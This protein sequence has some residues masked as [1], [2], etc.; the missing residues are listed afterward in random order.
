DTG[1]IITT[2]AGGGIGGDGGPA[3]S[4]ALD[5]PQ[6]VAVDAA[7]NLFIAEFD[8]P[9]VRKVDTAGII[10]TVAGNG[11][12]GFFGDGGPATSALL[13]EPAGVAVDA[14]GNLFIADSG[15][16]RIRKVTGGATAG[17]TVAINQAAGQA[18]PTG[19]EPINFTVVFNEP[20]TGFGE[21]TLGGTA[22]DGATTA[23]IT[24][25]VPG[26]LYNVE[27]INIS[28]PGTV[29]ASIPAGVATG[30]LSGLPNAVSVSIDNEVTFNPLLA[31]LTITKTDSPD[32]VTSNGTLTYTITVENIG[33]GDAADVTV[34][35]TLPT[36]VTFVSCVPSVG[37]C[38]ELA[39]IVTASLGTVGVEIIRTVTITV[40]APTVTTEP[41]FLTNTASVATT[42]P[43]TNPDNNQIS[44][45]TTVNPTGPAPQ[46]GVPNGGFIPWMAVD[47]QSPDTVYAG[48]NA[49]GIYKS[50]NRGFS[51]T[52]INNGLE[53][54]PH[55]H[56]IAID[57][58]TPSTV[59]VG[60]ATGGVLKSLDGGLSWSDSN[61]QTTLITD[62]NVENIAIDPVTPTTL[63]AAT[64]ASGVYKSTD[65]G[66]NWDPLTGFTSTNAFRIAIDPSDP[67][68]L[69]VGTL[70]D[71]VFKSTDGGANWSNVGTVSSGLTNLVV[72]ALLI[73]PADP[74]ILFAGTLYDGT[75][76]GV[77][78]STDGGNTW[79]NVGRI[80]TGLDDL[81][82]QA[83]AFGSIF[84]G[85]FS[86]GVFK[87]ANGDLW[88]SSNIGMTSFEI[89]SLASNGAGVLYAGT[90]PEGIFRSTD[91]GD[92][93]IEPPTN[94]TIG[95][96]ANVSTVTV[97]QSVIYTVTVNN[98]GKVD[99]ANVTVKDFIDPRFLFA[100]CNPNICSHPGGSG[101]TATATLGTVAAGGSS[102]FQITLFAVGPVGGPVGIPNTVDVSTTTPETDTSTAS[103]RAFAFVTMQP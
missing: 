81:T 40:T 18:D 23:I 61:G 92:S 50:T 59:Y 17:S 3:T 96:T 6:G 67:Q 56:A 7:G 70:G 44:A 95:I 47:P 39:G 82:V 74:N 1:G 29:I 57:P 64:G 68:T 34:T 62:P 66:D 36:G 58:V 69:Y 24:G 31:E 49:D 26:A 97:G 79:S 8:T 19:V 30:T 84:A 10:T 72:A 94:L 87:S 60:T 55:V 33:G 98:I 45:T 83:L 28:G 100:G 15:N 14:A 51:W 42:S 35:D 80:T 103:N 85:T 73:D 12:A 5:I 65:S 22:V 54:F 20:V 88:A 63:Y 38:G 13:D 52:A 48:T 78:R 32:P 76:G 2:V 4:A 43:E 77:F 86:S 21:V 46:V 71:G 89:R 102:S 75:N 11:T 37:S 101:G 93:W 41:T 25:S 91:G 16:H 90:Q 27:V 99:A 53:D 9:R